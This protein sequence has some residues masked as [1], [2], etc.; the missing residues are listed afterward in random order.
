M[1]IST[2]VQLVVCSIWSLALI[3]MMSLFIAGAVMDYVDLPLVGV[4]ERGECVWVQE[5]GLE[6]QA[7]SELPEGKYDPVNVRSRDG[8]LS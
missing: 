1:K 3:I 7:C 4:G 2:K 8:G 6:R 5:S